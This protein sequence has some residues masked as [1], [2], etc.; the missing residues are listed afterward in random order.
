M[1]MY[2]HSISSLT[3]FR[4]KVSPSIAAFF[5]RPYPCFHS[6]RT[7]VRVLCRCYLTLGQ[8]SRACHF[9]G[10]HVKAT[11]IQAPTLAV[12]D[13]PET[14]APPKKKTLLLMKRPKLICTAYK[15]RCV[16]IHDPRV[17]G[18]A[19]ATLRP[20]P[21]LEKV[22]NTSSRTGS[23][24]LLCAEGADSAG[25]LSFPAIPRDLDSVEVRTV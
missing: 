16:L 24:K 22:S 20:P 18:P 10:M 23:S 3:R 21:N 17:T 6:D 15:N 12:R 2:V 19:E 13:F 7:L 5:N 4:P 11:A 8:K 1:A 25:P 14:C 9:M